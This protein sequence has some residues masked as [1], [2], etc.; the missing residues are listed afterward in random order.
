MAELQEAGVTAVS[1][2]FVHRSLAH[3]VEQ[4]EAMAALMAGLGH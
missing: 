1:L 2:R 3:Y 4:L